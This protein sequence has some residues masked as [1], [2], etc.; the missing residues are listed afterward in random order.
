MT[1][2]ASSLVSHVYG[3]FPSHG[4]P[5]D[6]RY[7]AS[8]SLAGVV[9]D[10]SDCRGHGALF[11][12]PHSYLHTAPTKQVSIF[13]NIF[14]VNNYFLS[15]NIFSKFKNIFSFRTCCATECLLERW[16]VRPRATPPPPRLP[17]PRTPPRRPL[18]RPHVS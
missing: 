6:P 10:N 13:T 15:K 17:R 5:G 3:V 2:L 9:L 1:A 16:S 7:P 18:P 11:C 14:L 8:Y 4:Y 12:S